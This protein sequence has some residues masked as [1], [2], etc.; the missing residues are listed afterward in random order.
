[1]ID[2]RLSEADLWEEYY[3]NLNRAY[4]EMRQAFKQSGL[5]QDEIAER[6]GVDKG[7]ISKRLHSRENLT[8]R[9]HSF[10]A[11]AMGCRLVMQYVPYSQV[12]ATKPVEAKLASSSAYYILFS[13]TVHQ[14]SAGATSTRARMH[15][16]TGD[17]VRVVDLDADLSMASAA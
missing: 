4:G 15:M 9:T 17:D 11:S 13:D 10:M 7:L 3:T 12:A 8:L 6:L 1:M 2:G 5:S 14:T 16:D